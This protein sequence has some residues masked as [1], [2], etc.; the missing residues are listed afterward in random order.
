M[1]TKQ[2]TPVREDL[3]LGNGGEPVSS[4][5]PTPAKLISTYQDPDT[6]DII[7]VYDDG[8]EKIRKRELLH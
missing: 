3:G 7:D 2:N 1:A 4:M 6:G 5:T 8:S